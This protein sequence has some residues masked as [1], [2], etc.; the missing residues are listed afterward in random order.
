MYSSVFTSNHPELA[1]AVLN[2]IWKN[3]NAM[4]DP[5]SGGDAQFWGGVS[6]KDH[7][8]WPAIAVQQNK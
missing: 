1:D 6:A 8:V 7:L 5:A 2:F 3:R 4:A